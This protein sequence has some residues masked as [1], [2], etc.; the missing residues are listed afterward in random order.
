MRILLISG[1]L[2][3]MMLVVSSCGDA[4]VSIFI[5]SGSTINP[6]SITLN[7]YSMDSVNNIINGSV[8]CYAPESGIDTMT[9]AVFDSRG[10]DRVRMTTVLNIQGIMNGTI[11]FRINYFGYPADVYTFSLFLTDF[12]GYTS[13]IITGSFSVP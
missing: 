8:N 10:F 12:N 3:M 7:Y 2:A 13:N 1:M 6:P 4:T 5:S 9:V 11:P